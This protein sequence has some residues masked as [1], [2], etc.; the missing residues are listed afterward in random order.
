[1]TM[2]RNEHLI[3]IA[4]VTGP[5]TVLLVA[6]GFYLWYSNRITGRAAIGVILLGPVLGVVLGFL[7]SKGGTAA[8]R[9]LAH[10]ITASHGIPPAPSY[11]LQESLIARGELAMARDAFETHLSEHPDDL[12]ARLALAALW[13][14]ELGDPLKAIELYLEIRPLAQTSRQEFAIANALIDLYRKTGQQ[15]K[16]MAELARF[17][18]RFDGTEAAAQA[19]N[20]LRRRKEG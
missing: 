13:R 10:T 7:I 14:D 16:E 20:A 6:L 8:G 11:S 2:D 3:A 12:D 15:G 4:R 19:R 1:M 17:A 18:A 9:A 5:A